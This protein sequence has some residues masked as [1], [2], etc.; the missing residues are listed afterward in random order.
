MLPTNMDS[1]R[2]RSAS[3]DITWRLGFNDEEE[4]WEHTLAAHAGLAGHQPR[5]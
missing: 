1:A 5:M 3:S 4:V 2:I